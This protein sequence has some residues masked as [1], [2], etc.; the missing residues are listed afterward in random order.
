MTV[1]CRRS[2]SGAAGRDLAALGEAV[3]RLAFLVLVTS[4]RL[5]LLAGR[6][7]A[8]APKVVPHW[9]QNLA[10]GRTCWPQLGQTR[11]SVVPHSSQNLACSGFSKPQLAQRML[12]LY[13]FRHSGARKTSAPHGMNRCT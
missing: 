6:G 4:L 11:T 8:A 13:S 7:F 10:V 9:P 1:N 2:A 3:E 12:P 5:R